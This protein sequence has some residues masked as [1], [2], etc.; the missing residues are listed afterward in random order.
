MPV[1]A[2]REGK[3][4]FQLAQTDGQ[5]G[6]ERRLPRD[7]EQ[8]VLQSMES[9]L[10]ERRLCLQQ[11]GDLVF[12][13][14]CGRERPLGPVPPQY[15]VSYTIGGFLDDIYATLIVKLAHCGSF[16]LKDLWRDAADLQTIGGDRLVG[17]RLQRRREG[18]G[19]ILAHAL[20]VTPE[21]QIIFASYI[22]K[23]LVEQS[24]ATVQRLRRYICPY[25]NKSVKDRQL[26][27]ERLREQGELAGILCQ[28]CEKR[29]QLW[30]KMEELFADETIR[31]HVQALHINESVDL[32]ARRLRKLLV[33]EVSAR[34]VSA[35][36]KCIE[37]PQDQ[38]EGIDLTVEFTDQDGRGTA[39]H[40]YLQLKAGNSYLTKRKSD[41]AEIFRIQNQSYID[42][43]IKV[44]AD[45]PVM[46]VIGTFADDPRDR[47]IQSDNKAF[48][49]VRWMEIGGPLR[50]ERANGKEVTQL[51]FNGERLDA[52][53]VL[54]W[55]DEA[56]KRR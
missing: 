22:H 52:Q 4:I 31:H 11:E 16:K 17:V 37:V 46:L 50:K 21:E 9:A 24:T 43:W 33:H 29:I 56:L 23:H 41:G 44:S 36:Q 38:D 39:R 19:E 1:R 5:P 32:D 15:F 7:E 12:P 35:D 28:H 8:I 13:S 3:L 25:C 27:M 34:L 30:D 55:R 45:G 10:L 2:I 6:E 14:Y 54:Y 42:Y 48:A 47:G 51:V 20:D 26:A 53:S 18:G 40:M 49:D